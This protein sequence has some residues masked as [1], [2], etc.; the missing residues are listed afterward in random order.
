VRQSGVK[1]VFVNLM[2]IPFQL[3]MLVV[4]AAVPSCSRKV[5]QMQ[6]SLDALN[7]T[8]ISCHSRHRDFSGQLNM[9][10]LSA[11]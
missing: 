3:G 11:Q 2:K 1:D 9:K 6:Q 5:E 7:A 8:C 10:Q 4:A